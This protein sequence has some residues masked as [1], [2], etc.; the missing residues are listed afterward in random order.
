MHIKLIARSGLAAG[1]SAA[2]LMFAAWAQTA[3]GA[4]QGVASLSG[5]V[6][7][8][9][10][11]AMLEQQGQYNFWLTTAAKRSGAYLAGVQVRI[12]DQRTRQAV[13][14]QTLD[15]PWLLAALAPGRY[16]VEA[17]YSDD[18]GANE[19][20]VR[21]QTTLAPRVKIRQMVLYFDSSASVPAG[22]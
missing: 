10:R 22:N 3:G 18:A 20:T 12:I 6:G 21:Q 13:L 8:S 15:G 5:G 1:L 11:Q 16:L 4:A 7:E 14:E 19:Q 2:F 9:E 17:R